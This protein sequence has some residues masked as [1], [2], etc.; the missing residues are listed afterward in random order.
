MNQNQIKPF[1]KTALIAALLAEI[2][3]GA[4][5]ATIDVDG[6][7]C[8]FDEAIIAACA[9]TVI[10]ANKA[11]INAVFLNGLIRFFCIGLPLLFL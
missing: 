2:T 7:N 1:K 8:T 9:P 6:T 10:S 11:A 5:A 3:V 4:Q